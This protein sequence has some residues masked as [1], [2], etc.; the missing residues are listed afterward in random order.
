MQINNMSEQ[1]VTE[2][3]VQAIDEEDMQVSAE[4]EPSEVEID[5]MFKSKKRAH[6][7]N[8]NKHV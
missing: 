4:E 1:I 2:E 3:N 8:R 5:L 7:E 6:R